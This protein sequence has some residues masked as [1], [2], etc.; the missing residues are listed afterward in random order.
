[1]VC[2]CILQYSQRMWFVSIGQ[3]GLDLFERARQSKWQ[4]WG[5]T[6]AFNIRT[7]CCVVVCVVFM[8]F[9]LQTPVQL[10]DRS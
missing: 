4:Q 3:K 2:S 6:N 1:V 9:S 7:R 10:A 5:S 8:P